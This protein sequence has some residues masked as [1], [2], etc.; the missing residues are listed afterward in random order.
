MLRRNGCFITTK[1]EVALV[2][3]YKR[4]ELLHFVSFVRYNF[5]III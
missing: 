3:M 4:K 5:D 1:E 2:R